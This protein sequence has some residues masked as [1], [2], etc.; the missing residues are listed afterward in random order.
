MINL[1]PHTFKKEL[2][3]EENVRILFILVTSFGVFLLVLSFLL[4][5]TLAYLWGELGS[6]KLLA[7]GFEKELAQLTVAREE[8]EAKKA[9]YAALS[10]ILQRQV[11]VTALFDKLTQDL[12]TG[13]SLSSLS[14]SAARTT[15]LK[16]ETIQ[17][18][19]QVVLQGASPSREILSEVRANLE[20]DIFFKDLFFPLS[21]FTNLENFS[22]SMKVNQ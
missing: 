5:A 17:E 9:D 1:L 18:S 8:F 20:Q 11:S 4:L 10:G 2:K 12:P 21:N 3:D 16:G 19:S 6:Q 14:F 13:V 22:A 15:F 7:S